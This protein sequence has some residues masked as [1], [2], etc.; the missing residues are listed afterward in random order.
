MMVHDNLS[1]GPL[2]YLESLWNKRA[3]L[4]RL[5]QLIKY[6][7]YHSLS[8]EI[9]NFLF[10]SGIPT[11]KIFLIPNGINERAIYTD[12]IFFR[13][14]IRKILNLKSD[15]EI[16]TMV[17][18][19]TYRKGIYIARKCLELLPNNYH[20]VLI[21]KPPKYIG[22]QYLKTILG[23]NCSQRIHYLGHQSSN[24]IYAILNA[25]DC[26]LSLSIS[27]ACQLSPLEAINVGVPVI[28]TDCGAA[29]DKFGSDYN[30]LIPVSP[31]TKLLRNNIIEATENVFKFQNAKMNWKEVAILMKEAYF[32]IMN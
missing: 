12:R 2:K 18:T 1:F 15:D 24:V 17:G 30:F 27:G 11:S 19:I 13:L 25:S 9:I 6:E 26:F 23:G 22:N 10:A 3:Q 32:S 8:A 4:I 5:N 14:E 20:L 28:I 16:L 21:G 7:F 29:R 31:N